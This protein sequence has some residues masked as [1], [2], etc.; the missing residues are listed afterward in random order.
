MLEAKKLE[1]IIHIANDDNYC[2]LYYYMAL[3][4]S[5]K[6]FEYFIR[7]IVAFDGTTLKHKYYGYLNITLAITIVK[8][9]HL[10]LV[11]VMGKT[12]QHTQLF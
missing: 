8:F 10:H 12:K 6:G 4:A 1:T 11:L 5:I 7:P 2:F 9:I 3:D